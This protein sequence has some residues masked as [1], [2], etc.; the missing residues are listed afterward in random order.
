MRFPISWLFRLIPPEFLARQS[1]FF[2]L[3]RHIPPNVDGFLTSSKRKGRSN[4]DLTQSWHVCLGS[5]LHEK[6]FL[7]KCGSYFKEKTSF[8]RTI[9]SSSFLMLKYWNKTRVEV[10]RN[11]RKFWASN[12]IG[13]LS[14]WPKRHISPKGRAMLTW[15][16][17]D[18]LRSVEDWILEVHRFIRVISSEVVARE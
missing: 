5:G 11:S 13:R 2:V 1:I 15:F 14:S 12:T 16:D 6:S 4:S 8:Q 9:W 18:S 3:L 7:A 10:Y 17:Q